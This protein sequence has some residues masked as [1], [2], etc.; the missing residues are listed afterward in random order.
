MA[1]CDGYIRPIYL[2]R[3]R[4]WHYQIDSHTEPSLSKAQ[5]PGRIS[6]LDDGFVETQI[7]A[8]VHVIIEVF[9]LKTILHL[10]SHM[11]SGSPSECS[12]SFLSTSISTRGHHH[13][14]FVSL[15][16]LGWQ[17]IYTNCSPLLE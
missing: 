1:C 4:P 14:A 8:E 11:V 2:F 16:V 17:L 12:V 15:L 10:L 6:Q 9:K 13:L 5:A 3:K 7:S